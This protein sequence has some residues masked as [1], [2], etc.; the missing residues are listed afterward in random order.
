MNTN[1]RDMDNKYIH[2]VLLQGKPKDQD[3]IKHLD[4]K[5]EHMSIK[6]FICELIKRDME[7]SK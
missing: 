3:M 5:C 7:K 6:A 1:N 4:K 2:F